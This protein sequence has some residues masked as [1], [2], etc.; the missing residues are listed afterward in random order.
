M[1]TEATPPS[2]KTNATTEEI[3]QAIATLKSMTEG[4]HKELF[5][6]GFKLAKLG[7]T[8]RGNRKN[9]KNSSPE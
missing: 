6:T 9:T 2:F 7:L 4:R 3:D 5:M 8:R 1:A